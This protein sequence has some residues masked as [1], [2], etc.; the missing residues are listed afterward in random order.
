MGVFTENAFEDPVLP[1]EES[2]N[3][4]RREWDVK[5]ESQLARQVL[6]SGHLFKSSPFS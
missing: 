5:K 4:P 3:V 1:R 2:H 6:L